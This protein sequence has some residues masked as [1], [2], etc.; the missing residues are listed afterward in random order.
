MAEL[1][2]A[3]G[4]HVVHMTSKQ[5]FVPDSRLASPAS[6]E[7]GGEGEGGAGARESHS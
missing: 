6:V 2:K 1:L 5:A 3:R 7:G 4:Y